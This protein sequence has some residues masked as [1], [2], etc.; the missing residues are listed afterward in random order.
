MTDLCWLQRNE[1]VG[2]SK[3]EGNLC[4]SLSRIVLTGAIRDNLATIASNAHGCPPFIVN[5]RP[6]K[7]INQYFNKRRAELQHQLGH[8]GTTKRLER[9]TIKRNRRIDH[10]LHTASKYIIAQLVKAGIGQIVIGQNTL[11]KQECNLEARTNQHFCQ[12][13]HARFISMLAY[14]AKKVGITVPLTEESYTS[15]ASLLDLDPLPVRSPGEEARH[16][17]SGKRVSR[18]LYRASDGRSI[19]ADV[20]GAGNILYQVAPHAWKLAEGVEDDKGMLASLVV[21]PVRVTLP[22][23][24]RK[25]GIE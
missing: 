10:Y 3:K 24:S 19:N 7:S 22:L 20:N 16:T 5:G 18:G 8:L 12:I 1:E 9:L 11:W 25:T 15:K 23:R 4:I 13:P 14:K 2:N 6:V 17:F 21:H